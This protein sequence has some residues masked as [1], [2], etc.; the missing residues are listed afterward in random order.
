MCIDH[1]TFRFWTGDRE[2][3]VTEINENRNN[4]VARIRNWQDAIKLTEHF[5]TTRN[6]I[7]IMY[8]EKRDYR[9]I[10]CITFRGILEFVNRKRRNT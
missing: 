1:V 2:L 5:D 8:G 6:N 3:Y 9:G 10:L 7:V 4:V